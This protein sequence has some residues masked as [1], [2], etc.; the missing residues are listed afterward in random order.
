MNK[1]IHPAVAEHVMQE[2]EK[3]RG[4]LRT[5]WRL[6]PD[7]DYHDEHMQEEQKAW[8]IETAEV[9]N[10]DAALSQQADH[11]CRNCEGIQPE[12]CMLAEPAPAQDE[13]AGLAEALASADWPN[14]SVG[15][16][17]LVMRAIDLLTRP[18][19]TEQQPVAWLVIGEPFDGT[20]GLEAGDWDIE[21]VANL[22]DQLTVENSPARIGLYAAPVAQPA[23]TELVEALRI[24]VEYLDSNELNSIASGS[25][26]HRKMRNALAAQGGRDE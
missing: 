12:S 20:E 10:A 4:L 16:K 24:T 14:V 19:Q 2:N 17:A 7:R 26:C 25:T 22:I 13:R 6:R 9:L 21:P 5:A 11:S 23:Q 3:L 8:E 18:A 15:N 1:P